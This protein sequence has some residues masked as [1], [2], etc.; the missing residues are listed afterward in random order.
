[1]FPRGL[2]IPVLVQHIGQV[3]VDCGGSMS[4][5]KRFTDLERL[6]LEPQRVLQL[7]LARRGKRQVVQRGCPCSCIP[8]DLSIFKAL[9]EVFLG[10][11][12]VS[13]RA[14]KNS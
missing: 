8:Q 11:L 3:A 1:M 4:V 5:A 13:S 7:A 6:P 2:L 10:G 9:G 12:A 14:G